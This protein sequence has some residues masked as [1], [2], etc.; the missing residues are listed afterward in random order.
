ME[1]G[2]SKRTKEEVIAALKK[3]NGAV[4]L[5][6]KN[7]GISANTLFRYVRKW[8]DVAAVIAESRGKVIDVAENRLLRAIR[9]GE[10][11]AIAFCLKTIG[12][13]R[14]YVEP[15]RIQFDASAL[16]TEIG[17]LLAGMAPGGQGGAAPQVAEGGAGD[18]V[19]GGPA[20]D[21]GDNDGGP[22]GA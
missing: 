20:D 17:K 15:H 11:W 2:S 14:G 19:P 12:K 22:D 13:D 6:A 21:G 16:D 3:T 7:L 4:Y 8:K 5:A 10:G 1:A 18:A 9:K